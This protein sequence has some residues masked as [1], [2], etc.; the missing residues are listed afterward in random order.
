MDAE[1]KRPEPVFVPA[2]P[3]DELPEGIWI[4]TLNRRQRRALKKMKHLKGRD[5]QLDE[6]IDLAQ[7]TTKSEDFKQYMYKQTLEKLQEKSMEERIKEKKENENIEGNE[8]L[9]S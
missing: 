2:Q 9:Q 7:N 1:V 6:Y 8:E 5:P 4:P 3:D